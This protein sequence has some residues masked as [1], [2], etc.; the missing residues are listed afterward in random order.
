MLLTDKQKDKQTNT[1]E[2]ITSFASEVVKH[3]GIVHFSS[4]DNYDHISTF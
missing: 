3:F 1:T 4:K 2:N